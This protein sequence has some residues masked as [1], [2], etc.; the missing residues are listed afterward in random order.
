MLA[1]SGVLTRWLNRDAYDCNIVPSNEVESEGLPVDS[2]GGED[3]FF[4]VRQHHI[5]HLNQLVNQ[6]NQSEA[7]TW[8]SPFRIPTTTRP[9]LVMISTLLPTRESNRALISF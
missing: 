7:F 4:R 2:L 8:S 5:Y 3:A 9:S 1:V 6:T